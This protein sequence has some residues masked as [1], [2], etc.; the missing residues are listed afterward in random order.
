[1]FVASPFP[2]L[3][4][5]YFHFRALPLADLKVRPAF[6]PGFLRERKNIGARH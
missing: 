3:Y 5:S 2:T 4:R 6:Q 1:L